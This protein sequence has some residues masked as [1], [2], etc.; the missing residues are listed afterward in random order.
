MLQ[1]NNK[2]QDDGFQSRS[3]YPYGAVTQPFP[4]FGGPGNR[5]SGPA[6]SSHTLNPAA[7]SFSPNSGVLTPATLAGPVQPALSQQYPATF[8][9]GGGYP[10]YPLIQVS[11]MPSSVTQPNLNRPVIPPSVIRSTSSI[12]PLPYCPQ[13]SH[14]N[15]A[16][17][18]SRLPS[19]NP[20]FI[21]TIT[22]SSRGY[23]QLGRITDQHTSSEITYPPSLPYFGHRNSNTN[24]TVNGGM[25]SNMNR[26]W[27]LAS[28]SSIQQQGRFPQGEGP[29]SNSHPGNFG[30]YGVGRG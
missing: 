14:G 12:S 20:G 22:D 26:G 15:A 4:G 5:L 10:V 3:Q 9:H 24:G 19:M 27:S 8:T 7:V 21:P 16:S 23:P 18:N 29:L 13:S 25:G 28:A 6:Q 11:N 1:R 30:P 17:G 2:E